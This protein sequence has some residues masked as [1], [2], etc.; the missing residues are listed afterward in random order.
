MFYLDDLHARISRELR[1]SIK[2]PSRSAFSHEEEITAAEWKLCT[3]S[4]E[5][6]ASMVFI[7]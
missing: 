2:R 5:E 6:R 7:S 1:G 3:S 4:F